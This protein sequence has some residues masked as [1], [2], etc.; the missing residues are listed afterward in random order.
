M[1]FMSR[2]KIFENMESITS[3]MAFTESLLLQKRHFL[4]S[5]RG[6]SFK[7][8]K[9]HSLNRALQPR[10]K[11]TFFTFKKCGRGAHAPHCLPV[12]RPLELIKISFI[13]FT[14]WRMWTRTEYVVMKVS[15]E[16]RSKLNHQ[17]NLGQSTCSVTSV[18]FRFPVKCIK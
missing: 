11:G 7:K 9:F 13:L 12:P 14:A 3:E 17:R 8:Y 5:K 10:K 16:G 1:S 15:V 18:V 6:R 4:S 2:T